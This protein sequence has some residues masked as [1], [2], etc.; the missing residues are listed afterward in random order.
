MSG[1]FSQIPGL[2]PVVS[3]VSSVKHDVYNGV[4]YY[5]KTDSGDFS[6]KV[7]KMEVGADPETDL[8]ETQ[9]ATLTGVTSSQFANPV[10]SVSHD[11]TFLLIFRICF[12]FKFNRKKMFI[13]S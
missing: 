11:G 7:Y 1:Y 12:K 9:L 3:S 10:V 8:T 13:F 4:L 5:T 6:I 2:S